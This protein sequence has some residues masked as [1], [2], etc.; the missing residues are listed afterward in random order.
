MNHRRGTPVPAVLSLLAAAAMLI[1][2]FA[3]IPAASAACPDVDVVFARG[4]NEPPGIGKVGTAFVSALRSQVPA[5]TVQSYGVKY[6]ANDNFLAAAN[7]A[8]DASGHIQNMAGQ[9]PD[10]KLVLG[11]YSQGAAV[12]DIVT[13]A[14]IGALGYK[15]PL[16]AAMADH[17]AAVAVFGNPSS[18]LGQP[19]TT[20]SP[21]YGGKTIDLC[22]VGDPICTDGQNWN[23]H[24]AYVQ[25][26]MTSQAA[27]F[28]AARL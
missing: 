13:A 10:T 1:N 9:C 24:L 18:R 14:P 12:I 7:G 21:Q 16:P 2:P 25:T 4:T 5:K 26:G 15:Q 23:A 6:P 28:A 3:V 17:V 11:G 19:L 22:D 27:Q 8:N 20:L